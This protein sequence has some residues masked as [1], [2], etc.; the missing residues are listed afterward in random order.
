MTF[1]TQAAAFMKDL[2]TRVQRPAKPATIKL[3]DSYLRNHILPFLAAQNLK[4]IKNGLLK[5]FVAT[6]V[7]KKLAP[8]TI[9][10]I[11][12]VTKQVITSLTNDEGDILFDPTWNSDFIG[13]PVVN[14]RKQKTPTIDAAGVLETP[15]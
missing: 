3:Y 10:G 5:Q 6:L 8:A 14:P 4:V 2:R 7:E 1:G 12:T 9:T 13:A 15:A 11:L